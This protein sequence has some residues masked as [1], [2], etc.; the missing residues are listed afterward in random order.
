MIRKRASAF[1]AAALLSAIA[2]PSVT[3][4]DPAA[5]PAVDARKTIV[6]TDAECTMILTEMRQF[7][8][9]VQTIT[10][11]LSDEDFE[12]VAQ[13]AKKMG[14]AAA[15]EVPASVAAKLPAEFK[16]FGQST[17]AGFDRVALD[18]AELGDVQHSLEQ[19]GTLLG[20]CVAC[21]ATFRFESEQPKH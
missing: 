10:A 19:L 6:L 2:Q 16:R 7:L 15:Q 17:H 20:N 11:A 18:A 9:T 21:H 8:S 12:R 5:A 14:F 13:A 4:H 3:Q 1:V